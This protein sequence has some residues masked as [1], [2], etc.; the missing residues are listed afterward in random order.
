M[1]IKLLLQTWKFV[2][3][4]ELSRFTV[5]EKT[6]EIRELRKLSWQ[7]KLKKVKQ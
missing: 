4:V 2:D 5:L 6:L 1:P 7:K 3:N